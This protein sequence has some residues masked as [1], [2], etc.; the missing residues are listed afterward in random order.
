MRRAPRIICFFFCCLF[1]GNSLL[2]QLAGLKHYGVKEGLPASTVYAIT[3]DLDGFIWFGTEAGLV[4]FDGAEFKTYSTKDGLP[5]NEI[6]GLCTD[7]TGRLWITSYNKNLSYIKN[8]QVFTAK[9]DTLLKTL[10]NLPTEDFISFIPGRKNR[11]WFYARKLVRVSGNQV[12]EFPGFAS[13][14]QIRWIEDISD[15]NFNVY[16]LNNIYQFRRDSLVATY[17]IAAN[18]QNQSSFGMWQNNIYVFIRDSIKIYKR[19]PNYTFSLI[20]TLGV[21]GN[22]FSQNSNS[23]QGNNLIWI[24]NRLFV[25]AVNLGVYLIDDPLGPNPV[26]SLIPN[27]SK[28]L[29]KDRDNNVWVATADNGVFFYHPENSLTIDH[30]AGLN[31]ENAGCICVDDSDRI[32]IGDSKGAIQC[33][34]HNHIEGTAVK[35]SLSSF[36]KSRKIIYYNGFIY[37]IS[38]AG[39]FIYDPTRRI[40]LSENN[41][42]PNKSMIIS[43]KR[44]KVV[45]GAVSGIAFASK[46]A[47]FDF[48]EINVHQRVT[49]LCEDQ[50]GILYC[51]GINGLYIWEDSMRFIGYSNELLKKRITC[52]AVSVENIIWIATSS[53]GIIGYKNGKVIANINHESD[54][55]FSGVMCRSVFVDGKNNLWVATNK[56]INKIEYTLKADSVIIKSISPFN[57]A[58]GLADDDV[59]DVYVRDSFVYAATA[60][61]VSVFNFYNATTGTAPQVYITGVAINNVDTP[62]RMNYTFPYSQNNI[63]IRFTGLSFV[64]NGEIDYRYKLIGSDD[65]WAYTNANKVELKSLRDGDYT[66]VVEAL[67]RSGRASANPAS[68]GFRITPPF[69]L[70]WWFMLMAGSVFAFIIYITTRWWFFRKQKNE[71]TLSG[72]KDKIAGLEQQALRSQMNPHFIFNSLTAIQHYINSEDAESANKYLIS[73]SKL[74]RKTLDN[75]ESN[76]ISIDSEIQYLENYI[77]LEQMRFNGK[78]SYAITCAAEIDKPH[79][80]IPVMLTQPFIEN[81]IRHGL[82]YKKENDGALSISFSKRNNFLVCEIEDNGVGREMSALLKTDMHIEYQ[83]KGMK[84]SNDRIEAMNNMN[85]GKKMKIEIIDKKNAGGQG[86]GTLVILYFEQNPPK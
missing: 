10:S 21:K 12:H 72:L 25:S 54:R 28:T 60:K 51:G 70:H 52:M 11:C 41:Y 35:S 48:T 13:Q 84:I 3:Q 64:N 73:F 63:T 45:L 38:D 31:D 79:I 49:A 86:E 59:N 5:D 7:S 24:K 69:Y 74:V 37:F 39:F 78:F 19:L 27:H 26:I 43:A 55:S 1:I 4:R 2:A 75:S 15:G 71:R 18:P 47:P 68:I 32:W 8:G 30:N 23:S 16:T 66:F 36:S 83:S 44:N 34:H 33:F 17:V 80:Y 14:E 56:G 50:S 77:Q 46:T 57:T 42:T 29:F 53:N 82:R 67:D 76:V 20:K 61:G 9:N 6:L 40:L 85:A 81:A 58:D 62:V 22:S 65:N